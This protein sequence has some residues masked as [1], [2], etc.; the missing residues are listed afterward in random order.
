MLFV[1]YML[2]AN[3]IHCDCI[4]SLEGQGDWRV[5]YLKGVGVSLCAGFTGA[6]LSD[7][8]PEG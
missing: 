4:T 7:G 2:N 1:G 8:A 6:P 5:V 3:Q